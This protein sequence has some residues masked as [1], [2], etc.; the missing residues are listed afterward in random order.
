MKATDLAKAQKLIGEAQRDKGILDELSSGQPLTLSV[1]KAEFQ[2]TSGAE[3][4]LR[5]RVMRDL[6]ERIDTAVKT[7]EELGVEL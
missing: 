1:G 4:E 5:K 6:Q 3:T 7:L 2:L